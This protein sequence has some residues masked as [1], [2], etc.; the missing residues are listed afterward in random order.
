MGSSGQEVG[1]TSPDIPI[2]KRHH[3]LGQSTDPDRIAISSCE[4]EICNLDSASIIHQQ[5]ASLQVSMKNPV[6]MTMIYGREKLK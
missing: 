2:P 4:T 1:C 3:Q 6:L 5:I